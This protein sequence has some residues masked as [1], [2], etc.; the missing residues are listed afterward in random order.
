MSLYLG[1]LVLLL[2]ILITAL[3]ACANP[4]DSTQSRRWYIP[5]YVPLQFAGNIGLFSLGAGYTSKHQ[6]YQLSL[7]YGYVPYSV[8]QTDIHTIT[9]KNNFPLTWYG[10]KNN[11]ML[12]PYLGLGLSAEVG[13]NA[14]F[15]MPSHFPDSY[16]DAPKNLRILAYGGARLQH[17]FSEDFSFLRGVEFY[18]EAGTV[19]VYLWYKTLSSEIKFS[20][21]FSLALG[22]NFLLTTGEDR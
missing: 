9:V 6:T 14:F 22:I 5:D 8:A 11:Q 21:V 16:Y 13:G 3:E 19:D 18:A 2:P 7:S 20:Q 15:K 17:L 12:I 1:R 4:G 10:L